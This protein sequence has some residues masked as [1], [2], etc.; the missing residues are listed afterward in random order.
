MA[1]KREVLASTW[2]LL[3]ILL[4]ISLFLTGCSQDQQTSIESD[5]LTAKEAKE[6]TM[7]YLNNDLLPYL[8]VPNPNATAVSVEDKG[9]VYRVVTK[10]Q[11][12]E[13][14]VY[15]S[16]DGEMLL[17]QALNMSSDQSSESQGELSAEEAKIKAVSYINEDL[18]MPG[19]VS[20]VSVEEKRFI[21]E[22]FTEYQGKKRPV[23]VTMDGRYLFFAGFN[24]SEK[25]PTRTMT[26]ESTQTP[27]QPSYS[28]EELQQFVNCL[29]QA[30]VKIYGAE[31]C[32]HCQDLVNMLG[33]YNV[34]DPIYVECTENQ[35]LCE[36]KDI[37]AY[38]TI[39]I[40]GS[41]YSGARTYQA[42]SQA[43]GCPAPQK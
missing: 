14:P 6:K 42:L 19:N 8:D 1:R 39:I 30:G 15:L 43:T 9:S 3:L 37:Q 29:D 23:Y 31:W 7:D 16:K 17:L 4:A 38:P 2:I 36:D 22:I 12:Q 32:S 35:Q 24:T 20:A 25:L 21:Y 10:F 26:P 5:E 40:N 18:E 33:G 41:K 28:T 11:G 27:T 13:A 34:V